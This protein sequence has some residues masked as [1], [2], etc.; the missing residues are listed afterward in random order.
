MMLGIRPN[1]V[2][3]GGYDFSLKLLQNTK[4]RILR[5]PHPRFIFIF[6]KGKTKGFDM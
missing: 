3:G 4:D 6:L 5:I 2:V 1:V